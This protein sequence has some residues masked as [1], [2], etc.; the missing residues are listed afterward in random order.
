MRNYL[1]PLAEAR[2]IAPKGFGSFAI[3]P[4]PMGTIVAT[5]GGT[6]VDRTNFESYPLE[7]RSRS[8]QIDE[9][10]FLLGPELR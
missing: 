1:S 8:I 4:I 6:I 5:F 10:Q 2:E 3:T 7:Q 9:D